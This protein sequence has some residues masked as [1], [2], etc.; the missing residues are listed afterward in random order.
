MALEYVKSNKNKVR[1]QQVFANNNNNDDDNDDINN[2][3]F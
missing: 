3:N 1:M 2:N